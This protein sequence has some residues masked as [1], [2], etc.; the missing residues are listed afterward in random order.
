MEFVAEIDGSARP[1][2]GPGGWGVWLEGPGGKRLQ[3][4]GRL[5]YTTN[6]QAEY[7]ALLEAIRLAKDQGATRLVVQTDSKL[8]VHQIQG[9][10]EAKDP[11]LRRLLEEVRREA[12]GLPLEMRWVPRQKNRRA[13]ALSRRA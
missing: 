4:S 7:R 13:D 6:N 9:K 2:P 3:A 12:E 10:W 1:N 11:K 8:L 5:P